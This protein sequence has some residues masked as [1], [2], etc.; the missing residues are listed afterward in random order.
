MLVQAAKPAIQ[1]WTKFLGC[2]PDDGGTAGPHQWAAATLLTLG[3]VA[4]TVFRVRMFLMNRS[5]WLDPAMLALNVVQKSPA[6]LL[7]PLALDQSAP[8]GFLIVSKLVGSMCNYEDPTLTILPLL[9]GLGALFLF[10]RLSCRIL[11]P[12]GAP[13]AFL[14]FAACPA[15]VFYSGEFKQ[16]SGDL[17]FSVLVLVVA[18]HAIERRLERRPLLVFLGT[19]LLAALFSHP[20]LLVVA[21]TGLA[22]GLHGLRHQ[23]RALAPLAGIGTTLTLLLGALY[24]FQMRAAASPALFTAHAG[25]FAPSPFAG[26]E[27]LRWWWGTID[28]FVR[29]PLGLG[30]L[31]LVAL[32]SMAAGA[33]TAVFSPRRRAAG[34]LLLFPLAATAAASTLHLYPVIAGGYPVK[35]RF[36]LFAAPMGF[37]LIAFGLE[38]AS[39]LSPKPV[40]V[41][42]GLTLLLAWSPFRTMVRWPHFIREEMRPAVELLQQLKGPGDSVYV[43]HAAAAAFRFY[44]RDHPIPFIRVG[45]SLTPRSADPH[46]LAKAATA[47]RLWLVVSHDY[48]KN[49]TRLVRELKERG[50][51]FRVHSFPGAWLF[52]VVQDPKMV[53]APSGPEG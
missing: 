43:Y 45:R 18:H 41:A 34:T 51:G 52:S 36:V 25:G 27:F 8:A 10:L 37:L 30:K 44:T 19:S 17:F 16:Y 28:G 31:E 40:I 50:V 15:A 47:P 23:R 46:A 14:P 49:R 11:G 35:A 13:L 12:T 2:A 29:H 21:G 3:L 1:R 39:R 20:A 9:F 4:G 33:I 42:A 53:P 38:A 7:G 48:G 5:L 24:L 32:A 6:E 26:W 22:L